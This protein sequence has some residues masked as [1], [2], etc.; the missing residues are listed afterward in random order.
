M[1]QALAAAADDAKLA[2]IT[3]SAAPARRRASAISP[4]IL[5]TML[6]ASEF[7]AVTVLGIGIASAYLED[8]SDVFNLLYLLTIAGTAAASVVAFQLL[9]LYAPQ[10][11]SRIPEQLSGIAGGL[12]IAMALVLGVVFFTKLGIEFSRVWLAMWYAASILTLGTGRIMLARNARQ[13]A[14][15]GRLY[16]RAVVYGTN[17]VAADVV[18]KLRSSGACDVRITGLFDDRDNGRDR[19]AISG[20]NLLGGIDALIQHCREE[21]TDIVIVALP[22]AGEHRFNDVVSKLSV[23]PAEIKMPAHATRIRFSPRMYSHIGPVAM[24][25]LFDKPITDWGRV[26]KWLFDTVIA[27]VAIV[28]LAPVML[29]VAFCIKRESRGPVFFKQKRYGFNNELIEVYK[30]RSMYSD[31]CDARAHKLVTKDDPRVTPFGRF[32]RKTSLDELPQLFNV[33]KGDLSLVGPRPHALSA[34]AGGQLY[35]EIVEGYFARHKVKP[36]IT[37]WAQINGWRGETDTE[38]KIQKRVEHDLYYIENWSVFLDLYILLK[39]PLTL[40]SN[41][42]AY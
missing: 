16:R 1:T 25:D 35:D 37:G 32:I 42:N 4:Q 38:E 28:L 21:L 2:S 36:G 10:K 30:F 5:C 9:G 39:T 19:P 14:Q 6:R 13:W 24:I 22:V 7:A 20:L 18:A 17:D 41:K 11:F 27:S 3:G 33:V 12:T 15:E 23:L 31:M 40:I 34:K 29:W 26:S 8:L